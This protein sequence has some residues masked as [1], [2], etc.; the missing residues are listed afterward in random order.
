[1][2]RRPPRST[3]FPYTT[4]FRSRNTA[5]VLRALLNVVER[6]LHHELGA[7]VDRVSVARG[8]ELEQPLGLPGEHLVRH[9]L[10]RL[11]QHHEAA[12]SLVA[13]AE[14]EVREPA[15]AATVAPLGREHDEVER[16]PGLHLEPR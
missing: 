4:L 16:M 10:E 6:H 7:Y 8:L 9:P 14:V 12:A 1:M 11:S 3:L 5:R 15:V 13:G 2:I